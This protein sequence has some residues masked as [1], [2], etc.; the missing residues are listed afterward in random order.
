M[1][2]RNGLAI[3]VRGVLIGSLVG[4][5][6]ACGGGGSGSVSGGGSSAS[7]TSVGPVSGF[8]SVYVNGTYFNTDDLRGSIT[9]ED[10]LSR[11]DEL[12]KGMILLVKADWDNDRREGRAR[13]V[14]YD[15]TLRG[16]L[17]AFSWDSTANTGELTVAG[18]RVA[19]DGRTVIKS[20]DTLASVSSNPGGYRVRVSAWRQ[21]DGSFRASFVQLR[22]LASRFLADGD[23]EVEIEGV[24]RDLDRDSQSFTINGLLVDYQRADFDDD[25]DDASDLQNGLVVEVEGYLSGGVLIA[26]EIEGEDD[27]F[28]DD[29]DVEIS[30]A[31][32]GDYDIERRQ[33]MLN[34]VV[35]QV[36]GR[37]EFDDGLRETRLAD[38]LFVKVEGSYRDGLLYAE[39][40]EP[41]DGNAELEGRIESVDLASGRMQ[42]SGVTVAIST[43]TLIEDDDDDDFRNRNQDLESL[44]AGQY[45]EIEGRQ[46]SDAA[47]GYLDAFKI[48]REDEDDD[49]FEIQGRVDD[50][51]SETLTIMGLT[52]NRGSESFSGIGVGTRVEIEYEDRGGVYV[53]TD[54]EIEDDDDDDDDD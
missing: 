36:T 10:G 38:G 16:P 44:A 18:Q 11:E 41:Q 34:G 22:P 51:N 46:R 26:T 35:V 31:I 53:I 33:F 50:I 3:A 40:I 6:A 42:V 4:A 8:G 1:M 17:S 45:V 21:G 32:S 54:L 39:E 20:A 23:R 30:G 9:S 27:W 47:G 15:D 19:L 25:L 7:G 29:D 5:L 14:E 13:S 28:D 48:E 12:E 2:K 37:T 52:L 43:N 49:D 24:I